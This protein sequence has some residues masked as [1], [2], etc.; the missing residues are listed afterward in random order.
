MY[1]CEL[2]MKDLFLL[3]A[4][5]NVVD[6]ETPTIYIGQIYSITLMASWL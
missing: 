6:I 2:Q 1:S 3:L 5:L 4:D